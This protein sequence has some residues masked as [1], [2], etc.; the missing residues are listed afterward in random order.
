MKGNAGGGNV[1]SSNKKVVSD[2]QNIFGRSKTADSDTVSTYQVS[3]VS[4]SAVLLCASLAS[5]ITIFGRIGHVSLDE[6]EVHDAI[7]VKNYQP[8]TILN[9]INSYKVFVR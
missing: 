9:L 8:N 3:S 1:T 6:N 2:V 4:L 5:C 7:F